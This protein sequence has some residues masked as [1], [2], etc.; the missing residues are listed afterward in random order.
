VLLTNVEALGDAL[1]SPLD[2]RWRDWFL[3]ADLDAAERLFLHVCSKRS[4]PEGS[5]PT[6]QASTAPGA[7]EMI[8]RAVELVASLDHQSRTRWIAR[9]YGIEFE[10]ADNFVAQMREQLTCHAASRSR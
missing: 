7:S 1:D 9:V 4:L 3:E 5:L 2:A 8:G 10:D 6:K